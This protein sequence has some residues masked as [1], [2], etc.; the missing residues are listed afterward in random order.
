MCA[1]IPSLPLRYGQAGSIE[2]PPQAYSPLSNQI[3]IRPRKDLE[4]ATTA[5]LDRGKASSP[6]SQRSVQQ[7]DDCDRKERK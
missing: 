6:F 4:V 3:S 1:A 5:L 7:Y 2:H